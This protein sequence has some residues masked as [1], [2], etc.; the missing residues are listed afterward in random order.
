VPKLP[1]TQELVGRESTVLDEREP[2]QRQRAVPAA[3]QTSELEDTRST[4]ETR[5]DQDA[6]ARGEIDPGR[7]GDRVRTRYG[8]V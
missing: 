1:D 6:G 4:P 3:R 2:A 5:V 7:L 8:L